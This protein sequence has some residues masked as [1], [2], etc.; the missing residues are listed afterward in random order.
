VPSR[1]FKSSED[2]LVAKGSTKKRSKLTLHDRIVAFRATNLD[3]ADLLL[4]VKWLGNAGSHADM[5][6]ISRHDVLDGM[7]I[8]EHVLHLLFDKSGQAVTKLAKSINK[9]KGPL[10]KP[11]KKH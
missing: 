9:R 6:G 5:A 7:E 8:T 4:A 10:P 1:S 11:V 3:A 2:A